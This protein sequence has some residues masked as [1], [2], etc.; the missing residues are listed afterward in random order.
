MVQFFF[1]RLFRT[2]TFYIALGIGTVISLANFF[3]DIFPNRYYGNTPYTIWLESFSPSRLPQIYFQIFPILAVLPMASIYFKDKK[4]GYINH[5]LSCGKGKTY[6]SVMFLINFFAS[7]FTLAIPLLLNIY[8]CFMTLPNQKPTIGSMYS[9]IFFLMYPHDTFCMELY[10]QHPFLHLLLYV[11]IAFLIAGIMGS[12]GLAISFYVK[13]IFLVY[14]IPYIILNIIT[15]IGGERYDLMKMIRQSS[16][17]VYLSVLVTLAVL[18]MAAA[19]VIFQIGK[20][21]QVFL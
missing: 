1:K 20:R 5:I 18:L 17:D 14:L 13:K 11:L 10:Y 6:F 7:G 12:F 4:S 15:I 16:D 8:C 21:K 3:I 2:K 19:G 9:Q